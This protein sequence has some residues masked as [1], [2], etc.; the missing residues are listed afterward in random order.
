MHEYRS[1]RTPGGRQAGPGGGPGP[2]PGGPRR[3]SAA[4][5][6]VEPPTTRL[7]ATPQARP[8]PAPEAEAPT[9]RIAPVPPTDP[10]TGEGRSSLMRSSGVMAVAS[11]VSRV[12]GFLRTLALVAV[13]GLGIVNDS[14]TVANTLPNI[15]YE[16]LLGGVLTSVMIPL[17]VRAQTDDA[18]GGVRYTRRLLTLTG[19][20]LLLATVVAMLAAPSLT[21]LY[22]G[23][24]TSS[25]A[26]PELATLFAFLLL[27]QIF[28]YGI[29]ALLGAILNTRGVFGPFAWAPVLNNVV[30]LAVLGAYVAVPG[31]ISLDP[32]RMGDA[33]LLVLGL[34]TT[35]GIVVQAVVLLPSMHRIGFRYRPVWGW[36]PRLTAAGGLAGWVVLYVLIGQAG[37]IVT[38]R[39]A[40][41]AD[42]GSIATYTYAWLLLQV[43]YGV[44][45]VSLLTALM[46]RMSRAA[47]EG[48]PHD[49]VADLSLGTR[50]SAVALIPITVLLTLFGTEVG[51]ALFSLG[52][53]G[54]GGGS[55]RLGATLAASAFGLLP[56]AVTL[57]QLRVFYAL[58][59]SRTPTLI[60]LLIVGFKIPLLLLCPVLLAPEQVVL[61]LA[62]ANALSFVF[63]AMLGQVLVR[64]RLGPARTGEMLGTIARTTAASVIGGALAYGVVALLDAGPLE[65]W[66]P[67]SRA[68]VGLAVALAVATPVTLLAL[69][70]LRVRELDPLWRRLPGPRRGR[71]RAGPR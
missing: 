26:N 22:L 12:T 53:G 9:Q 11:L 62:A 43:P 24:Q 65:G 64:R 4:R 66:A 36:D 40:A 46:P 60:Q 23:T 49:V 15:V 8:R 51:V 16:L 70:L 44:L 59:D 69:R 18:D 6:P 55:A 71:K 19:V 21:R 39:V 13:L 58:T 17:L 68:W 37:Y 2:V 31:Q 29:G 10:A 56:Y 63:G 34:G 14:Y 27:P 28:F 3:P 47:A 33:K 7:P 50:L 35:L 38:T 54:A 61:G 5:P 41:D 48:R 42:A 32:V 20:A 1:P 25:S 57:L 67:V 30:V 52:A 45:G